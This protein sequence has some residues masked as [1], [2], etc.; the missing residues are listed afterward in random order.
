[1]THHRLRNALLA[2]GAALTLASG[3]AG[4]SD[5][6]TTADANADDGRKYAHMYRHGGHGGSA[7]TG[8][9]KQLDLTAEQ[10]QSIR[11]VFDGNAD[12]RK[13]LWDQQR[14][15][16]ESLASTL[17]DD[18]D[19]PT[20]IAT[21][22]DLAV[23]AIQQASDTQTQI[24]SLLTPEQKAKVPQLLAERKARREERRSQRQGGG[25]L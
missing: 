23:R 1:M 14:A 19:Y 6:S 18:P 17:P 25:K 2:A 20:L 5:S 12:K 24:Y 4:A 15:N 7:L 8:A 9:L 11:S 13:A 16:R 22:K 10:Q 3:I 21:Q